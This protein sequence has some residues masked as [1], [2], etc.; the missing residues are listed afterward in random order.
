LP[1]RNIST[2]DPLVGIGEVERGFETAAGAGLAF[3]RLDR[4][5]KGLAGRGIS[6]R[7]LAIVESVEKRAVGFAVGIEPQ[8]QIAGLVVP[9]LVVERD[10]SLA[11]RALL[12]P[13]D[14]R[15]QERE[16]AG[17]GDREHASRRSI[18]VHVR[19]LR[20]DV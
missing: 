19:C 1:R 3:H 18:Q 12:G 7:V 15:D 5:A 13:C 4:T 9:G 2:A 16:A 17:E 8:D 6:R 10:R 14:E 20:V 11:I